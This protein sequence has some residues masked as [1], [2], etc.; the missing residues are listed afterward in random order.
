[1]CYNRVGYTLGGFVLRKK[2]LVVDDNKLNRSILCMILSDEYDTI[3]AENGRV[4][5]GVLES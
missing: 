2:I 5:L 3:E 4:A 1:M